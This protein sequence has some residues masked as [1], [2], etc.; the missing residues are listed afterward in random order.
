M[1]V[2]K[3]LRAMGFKPNNHLSV[4]KGKKVF[5]VR[6][7]RDFIEREIGVDM[8]DSYE[9]AQSII[10]ELNIK[11][12]PKKIDVDCPYVGKMLSEETILAYSNNSDH[13]FLTNL[14]TWHSTDV[15]LKNLQTTMMA[16]L[17]DKDLVSDLINEK[18]KMAM[19][20]YDPYTSK[21]FFRSRNDE[22]SVFNT[23]IPPKHFFNLKHVAI[24][25]P[26]V[27][28]DFFFHLFNGRGKERRHFYDWLA[29]SLKTKN[30]SMALL[31]AAKGIGKNFMIEQI[32]SPLVG[33]QNVSYNRNE[34]IYG[35]FNESFALS[36]YALV[37]EFSIR[38]TQDMDAVKRLSND[39][40]AVEEKHKKK[41]TKK[42]KCNMIFCTNR[43]DQ[44]RLDDNQR[45]F[46]IYGTT[47]T[48]LEDNSYLMDK[49][50][51]IDNICD[52]INK[53]IPSFYKWL[54][55]REIKR[56][57]DVPYVNERVFEKIKMQSLYDWEHL[58]IDYVDN[59]NLNESITVN[60]MKFDLQDQA[61][62][63]LKAYTIINFLRNMKIGS[64]NGKG[65][66]A[67]FKK[68]EKVVTEFV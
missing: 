25:L 51:N 8:S 5:P 45:R 14:N 44:V 3:E 21:K 49:Y 35:R 68:T 33:E 42:I 13:A 59:M 34:D 15:R 40:M 10:D 64:I 52:L 50:G 48:K 67:V 39:T 63:K 4:K 38:T 6:E 19:F 17:H 62:T 26:E 18:L 11:V 66:A 57:L 2:I 9:L 22:D 46:N 20:D 55:G 47:N 31:V 37:D 30:R 29:N 36:Q 56:N 24:E 60:D 32:L 27:I 58:V 12:D 43:F 54:L 7:L 16:H 23:W 28:D 53:S 65:N 41:E 1:N 61:K